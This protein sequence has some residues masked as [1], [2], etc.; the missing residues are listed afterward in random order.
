MYLASPGLMAWVS[1][2][3]GADCRGWD[4]VTADQRAQRKRRQ[5]VAYPLQE[6]VTV[7]DPETMREVPRDGE[8]VGEV[9]FRGN[10]VMKGYLKNEKATKEAFAG[11]WFHTGDIGVLDEHGY[12]IIK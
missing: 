3:V 11:G 8:T 1:A 6:A 4:F 10:I 12:I 5:G 2:S 7:L 9:M